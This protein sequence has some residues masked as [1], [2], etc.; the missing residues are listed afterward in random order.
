M[1]K[2]IYKCKKCGEEFEHYTIK[3]TGKIKS[4][5]EHCDRLDKLKRGATFRKNK[6]LTVTF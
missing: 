6:T 2:V 3:N 1:P 5:C 4:L